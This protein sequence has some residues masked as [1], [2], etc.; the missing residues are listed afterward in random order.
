MIPGH[1]TL[2]VEQSSY[3]QTD[4][5]TAT[6]ANGLGGDIR[7]ADHQSGCTIVAVE[8]LTGAAW[9]LQHPCPLRSP[10]RLI[11]LAAGSVTAAAIPPPVGAWATGAYRL[12]LNYRPAEAD[13]V[14]TLTSAQFTV[15]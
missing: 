9:A 2:A 13:D 7:V 4:T 12:T 11:A 1:V 6:V 14:T 3:G 5:I 8:R 15:A 10:T